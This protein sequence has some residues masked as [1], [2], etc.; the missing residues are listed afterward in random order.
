MSEPI[1]E[2]HGFENVYG[3]L[4]L[5]EGKHLAAC[6]RTVILENSATGATI[7]EVGS[8]YGRSTC[9]IASAI[10]G[11]F[12]TIDVR[13][14]KPRFFA[15]DTFWAA[16]QNGYAG[17]VRCFFET[18]RGN[19]ESRGLFG[20]VSVIPG[21]S[22]AA[23][24]TW[25]GAKINFLFIDADHTYDSL[26][27]DW[28]AWVPHLKPGALVVLDDIGFKGMNEAFNAKIVGHAKNAVNVGKMLSF[29]YVE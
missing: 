18:F 27:Q 22:V 1:V 26:C 6:A 4:S 5:E 15:V 9:A 10:K 13:L 7:V 12:H 28:E 3:W 29:E 14:P 19:L 23:A 25:S 20:F 8:W 17:D 16:E 24:R 21:T 2:V 11:L